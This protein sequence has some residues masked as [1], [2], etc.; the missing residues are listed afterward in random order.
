M[1][2]NESS[3]LIAVMGTKVPQNEGSWERKSQGTKVT[4]MELSF[5]GTKVPWYESSSYRSLTIVTLFVSCR[6]TNFFS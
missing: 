6:C 1:F 2:G 4:P 3:P 5:L